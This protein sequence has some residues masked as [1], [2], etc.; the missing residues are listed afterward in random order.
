MS[1]I[2]KNSTL[3]KIGSSYYQNGGMGAAANAIFLP[4]ANTG[5]IILWRVNVNI[6]VAATRLG[7]FIDTAAPASA[8]DATKRQIYWQYQSIG[9]HSIDCP[10]YVPA[11]NGMWAFPDVGGN[12]DITVNW[13]TL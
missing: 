9:R 7:V 5:G 11:G 8:T 3:L 6:R 13:E 4:A 1:G 12:A 10:I 2:S